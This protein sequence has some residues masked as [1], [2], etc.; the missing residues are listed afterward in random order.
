M[1]IRVLAMRIRV[2]A[3]RIRV[4]A[5]RIRVLAIRIRVLAIRIRVPAMRIRVLAIRI[6][7]LATHAHTIRI[8][9]C[10]N[11]PQ[12]S[13]RP[14]GRRG[15]IEG[16]RQQRR[17]RVLATRS[18][19]QPP[20]HRIARPRATC[21]KP[22]AACA[23]A[24][25]LLA[26][27]WTSWV[28]AG[29]AA[30][31][32]CA[33]RA[34]GGRSA[35]RGGDRAGTPRLREAEDEGHEGQG[36]EARAA[37]PAEG[38]AARSTRRNVA[39]V[40]PAASVGACDRSPT[41]DR[42]AMAMAMAMAMAVTVALAHV[43]VRQPECF[44]NSRGHGCSHDSNRADT[45]QRAQLSGSAT[46]HPR[47]TSTHISASSSACAPQPV[48]AAAVLRCGG[49]C[50]AARWP[51]GG[52]RFSRAAAHS[53][54]GPQGAPAGRAGRAVV[55]QDADRSACPTR[56]RNNLVHRSDQVGRH[57]TAPPAP[58]VRA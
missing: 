22:R 45:L 55:V 8:R 25:L 23:A 43:T 4:L 28:L 36:Q 33:L 20:P 27:Q 13:A 47:S 10:G 30:A 2:L 18:G 1:R 21:S 57:R 56:T 16:M 14:S 6:R 9:T 58:C 46:Q 52:T 19:R 26:T 40:S 24:Q 50:S 44:A 54:T 29:L 3:M 41:I 39:P 42:R 32:C 38:R 15:R 12:T 7:V 31:V 34:E 51:C 17:R 37:R 48:A 11:R 49:T 53:G 35:D 5:I